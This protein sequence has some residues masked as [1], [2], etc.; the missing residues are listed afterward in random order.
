[1]NKATVTRERKRLEAILDSANVPQQKRE[2]LAVVVENIAFQRCKLEETR[3]LIMHD[4][5]ISHYDNG[6][7]QRGLQVNPMYKAYI[8][9]WRAYMIGME[10]FTSYL[11]KDMQDEVQSDG[12]SV[13]DQVRQMKKG[14]T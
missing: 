13:L 5:I 8:D 7:G 12:M 3:G 2:A 6:G 4:F 11:P 10:K 1:M 14:E 9:L